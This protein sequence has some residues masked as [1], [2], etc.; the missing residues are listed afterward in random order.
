MSA[1]CPGFKPG[2]VKPTRCRRCYKDYSE[3]VIKDE[4]SADRKKSLTDTDGNT[5]QNTSDSVKQSKRFC[6][7]FCLLLNYFQIFIYLRKQK[8]LSPKNKIQ[9]ILSIYWF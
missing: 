9:S 8:S 5:T 3:H 7:S 1:N 6:H 2:T 4:L